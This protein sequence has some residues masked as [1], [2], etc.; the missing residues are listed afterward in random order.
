M[1]GKVL[2]IGDCTVRQNLEPALVEAGFTVVEA[3]D[4]TDGLKHL[5]NA[6]HRIVILSEDV[7]FMEDMN[8][9]PILKRHTST[10]VIVVG[11]DG[12]QAVVN[13]LNQGAD[14]HLP[15]T[16]SVRVVLAYL[17]ALLRRSSPSPEHQM[18]QP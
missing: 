4:S 8:L 17:R 12:Q 2:V 10:P 3:T 14:V 9:L 7:P 18:L 16:T 13:S 5:R 11:S 1:P 15:R 6:E